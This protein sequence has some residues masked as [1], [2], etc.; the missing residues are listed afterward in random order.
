MEH[1]IKNTKERFSY[2][3]RLKLLSCL[4]DS[5]KKFWY[6]KLTV[7]Y[8]FVKYI[9]IKQFNVNFVVCKEE[10]DKSTSLVVCYNSILRLCENDDYA[11]KLTKFILEYLII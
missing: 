6:I 1:I 5:L 4:K 9:H 7:E 3:F 10:V 2:P 8:E 11:K